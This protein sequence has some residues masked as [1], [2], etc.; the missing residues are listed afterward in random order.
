MYKT[1]GFKK[2]MNPNSPE[3][4]AAE[5]LL[6]RCFKNG[7]KFLNIPGPQQWLATH[8]RF[9]DLKEDEIEAIRILGLENEVRMFV[10]LNDYYGKLLK[11]TETNLDAPGKLDLAEQQ[12]EAIK[13]FRELTTKLVAFANLAWPGSTKIDEDRRMLLLEPYIN[14]LLRYSQKH[15]AKIKQAIKKRKEQEDNNSAPKN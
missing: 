9:S 12:K 7:T 6:N 2:S 3:E 14:Q 4:D 11:I 8:K 1:L 10:V 13:K 15:S 5:L